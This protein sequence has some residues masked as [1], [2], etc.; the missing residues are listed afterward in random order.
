MNFLRTENAESV[1]YHFKVPEFIY[2]DVTPQGEG[3]LVLTD[4]TPEGY[5]TFN[6]ISHLMN[7]RCLKTSLKSLAEFHG[8]C[9]AFDKKSP[10]SLRQL[11]PIFDPG[12]L[13]WAQKDMLNFLI[14]VSHGAA[15]FLQMMKSFYFNEDEEPWQ[16]LLTS[17]KNPVALFKKEFLRSRNSPWKCLQ[18]GN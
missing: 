11:F 17:L 15:K 8:V 16:K 5:N 6:P 18:H 2:G 14:K 4:L 7:S 9:M 10:L 3:V 13:M 12:K 1:L